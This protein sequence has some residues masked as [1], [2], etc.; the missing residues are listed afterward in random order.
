MQVGVQCPDCRRALVVSGRR[1]CRCGTYL[2]HHWDGSLWRPHGR[3]LLM[4][5]GRWI[6]WEEMLEKAAQR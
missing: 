5:D 2:V 1:R 3:V 4:V 6:T